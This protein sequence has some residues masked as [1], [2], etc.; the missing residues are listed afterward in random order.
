MGATVVVVEA[1]IGD[2]EEIPL[3][4]RIPYSPSFETPIPYPGR[5]KGLVGTG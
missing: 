4:G 3:P 5:F 1:G 2:V